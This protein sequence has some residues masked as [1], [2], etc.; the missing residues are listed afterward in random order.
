MIPNLIYYKYFVRCVLPWAGA[1]LVAEGANIGHRGVAVDRFYCEGTNKQTNKQTSLVLRL[2]IQ[3]GYRNDTRYFT[4]EE[5]RFTYFP[6]LLQ[7]MRW[8]FYIYCEEKTWSCQIKTFLHVTDSYGS[9]DNS[10]ICD[11]TV[12]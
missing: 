6:L 10:S 1:V 12:Q 5:I 4:R 3:T 9:E 2:C 8:R 7:G 11:I